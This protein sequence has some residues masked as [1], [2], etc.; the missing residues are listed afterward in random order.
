MNLLNANTETA[1]QL[2]S[3]NKHKIA[4]RKRWLDIIL[5]ASI[6]AASAA[7]ALSLLPDCK[8]PG[9]DFNWLIAAGALATLI[10]LGLNTHRL[11]A[12]SGLRHLSNYPPPWLA[13][14]LGF[15][16]LA[17]L[18]IIAPTSS[19]TLACHE[20]KT[21]ELRDTAKENA[22]N[23]FL[24]TTFITGALTAG[25][26]ATRHAATR[27]SQCNTLATFNIQTPQSKPPPKPPPPEEHSTAS[28]SIF[29]TSLPQ[30]NKI[31]TK[32]QSWIENDQPLPA[33]HLDFLGHSQI[34]KRITSHFTS[35]TIKHPPIA[36]I[37]TLGSGKSSILNLIIYDL[38]A[39]HLLDSRIAIAQ[40]S[41][42]PF[43]TVEAAVRGILNSISREL[44][45]HVSTTPISG[46]PDQYI[47]TIEAAGASWVRALRNNRNPEEVLS[48]YDQ[49]ALAINLN[50]IIWVEDLERFAPPRSINDDEERLRPIRSLLHQFSKF[51]SLQVI[52]AS[53]SL[54]TRFDI[55]KIAR[56]VES[57]PTMAVE[58]TTKI[59][60]QFRKENIHPPDII[61]P[62]ERSIRDLLNLPL[63]GTEHEL[64]FSLFPSEYLITA[65]ATLCDNPRKLKYALRACLD[66]WL[67]LKGEID[68][69]DILSISIIRS[70]EPEVFATIND[71]IDTLQ[72]PS[73][74]KWQQD[75][76]HN[77]TLETKIAELMSS[78]SSHRHAATVRILDF[79]FPDWRNHHSPLNK[80]KKPQGV[81]HREHRNYWDR[82]LGHAPVEENDKDQPILAAINNWKTDRD[83]V[84]ALTA[85]LSNPKTQPT[86]E[87]FITA[88]IDGPELIE[89]LT[90]TALIE[91]EN[92]AEHWES[93]GPESIKSIWRSMTRTPPDES[94]LTANIIKILLETTPKNL[95]LAQ[96]LAHLFAYSASGV[97]HPIS[98]T[99]AQAINQ[100]LR[101]RMQVE[102][103]QSNPMKIVSALMRGHRCTIYWSAWGFDR[104]QSTS[105]NPKGFPFES[106]KP[107]SQLLLDAAEL[108]PVVMIPQILPFFSS[109]TQRISQSDGSLRQETRM[110]F[111]EDDARTLFDF[112]RLL[113][114]LDK[115]KDIKLSTNDEQ[116]A[117]DALSSLLPQAIKDI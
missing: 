43:D 59:L 84:A 71:N 76:K 33:P 82:Y 12:W 66:A 95:P 3:K 26:T 54:S 80:S 35:H 114:L 63:P 41:L 17:T 83:S 61:D 117:F 22:F 27:I 11:S 24:L 109:E 78:K 38:Q 70:A 44:G 53:S 88:I 50:I 8:D 14:L 77:N 45:R 4:I 73:S 40:V 98:K 96:S 67:R 23:I 86:A 74:R 19:I 10:S 15:S 20:L 56:Y 85:I 30:D 1:N 62:A 87:A 107:F 112:N 36:L 111:H 39:A 60:N 42:W 58:K 46:L 72:N 81:S 102:F 51:D 91:Q 105:S 100:Y 7:L 92:T 55:E 110:T 29:T 31:T 2:H 47:D 57:I 49:I 104:I 79:T 89:L 94:E 21:Q 34:A 18:T 37:G 52:L 106:W 16:L 6:G 99:N 9:A 13:A 116:A 69:D 25:H 64:H 68:F 93:M 108:N 32:L 75:S 103:I 65:L 97:R 48:S 101:S 28:T 90:A 113:E 5:M 115:N